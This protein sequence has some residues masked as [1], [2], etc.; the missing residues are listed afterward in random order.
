MDYSFCDS[1]TRHPVNEINSLVSEYGITKINTLFKSMEDSSVHYPNVVHFDSVSQ[2]ESLM[3]D[4]LAL[5]F[6][7]NVELVPV[8]SYCVTPNDTYYSSQNLW[9]LS[10]INAESAWGIHQDATD[11]IVA[12]LDNGFNIYHEDLNNNLWVNPGEIPGNGIDDDNNGYT[13]DV[14]GYDTGNDDGSPHIN[15]YN[16]TNQYGHGTH[17][18]GIAGAETNNSAGVASISFGSRLMLVKNSSDIGEFDHERAIAS[19]EYVLENDIDEGV[20]NMS[21][22]AYDGEYGL[23]SAQIADLHTVIQNLNNDGILLVAAAGNDGIELGNDIEHYPSGFPE[24]ISVGATQSDDLLAII[25]VNNTSLSSNYGTSIDVMAPGVDIMSTMSGL[26][27]SNDV[28]KSGSGTS[29]ASPLVAGLCALMRSYAPAASVDEIKSCLLST[30]YP[31]DDLNDP[32]YQGLLGSGRINAFEA[33][34]CLMTDDHLA[35]HFV[36]STHK[37]CENEPVTFFDESTGNP[38]S[39]EWTTTPSEGVIYSPSNTSQNPDIIFSEP[40]HYD[41]TLSVTDINGNERSVTYSDYVFVQ[42]PQVEMVHSNHFCVDDGDVGFCPEGNVTANSLDVCNGSTQTITLYFNHE[43]PF[44]AV[45]TDGYNTYDVS[46]DY[47]P[48]AVFTEYNYMTHVNVVVTEDNNTFTIESFEDNVCA[49]DTY[50]GAGITFNVHDC[51]PN[52]ISDGDFEGVTEIPE[53]RN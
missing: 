6:V 51:C 5:S 50:N 49:L 28:Y 52:L 45:V 38:V 20:V 37:A 30:C 53:G 43:P 12:I 15:T 33:L 13:D 27:G 41:M 23:T 14:H 10:H 36:S 29:M 1:M 34:K 22:G 3:N 16:S 8:Y 46:T 9:H 39:W 25:A 18:A 26:V 17:V 32:E 7:Y 24:V 21:W 11:V 44:R 42:N 31:I 2:T 40:G 4:F 35:A 19:L 48:C 47:Y